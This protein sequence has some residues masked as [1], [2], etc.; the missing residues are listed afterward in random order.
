MKSEEANKKCLEPILHQVP[1][2][3]FKRNIN[4]FFSILYR[5]TFRRVFLQGLCIYQYLEVQKTKS[6]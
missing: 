6:K 4:N 3:V 5:D 2:G 1:E